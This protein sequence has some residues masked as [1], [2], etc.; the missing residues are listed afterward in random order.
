MIRRQELEADRA[1]VRVAGRA[2]TA[3]ALREL[4]VLDAA[5][6]FFLRQYVE[7]AWEAGYVP[8]D[9]FG[10]FGQLLAGR[11]ENL[12]GLRAQELAGVGSRWDT[13]PPIATRISVIAVAPETQG[14]RRLAA[15]RAGVAAAAA[16]PGPPAAGRHDRPG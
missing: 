13:H 8:E 7:S 10:G 5:W 16:G 6:G 2:A 9:L 15:G 12:D 3:G 11:K 4:P 14:D 1:A